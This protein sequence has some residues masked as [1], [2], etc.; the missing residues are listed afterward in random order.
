MLWC[1]SQSLSW[2]RPHSSHSTHP[3]HCYPVSLPLKLFLCLVLLQTSQHAPCLLT[4]CC[5]LTNPGD[6]LI[7]HL[8]ATLNQSSHSNGAIDQ[9]KV[10]DWWLS[11]S[12]VCSWAR[13]DSF[14]ENEQFAPV[15]E[16]MWAAS[17]WLTGIR[18]N[19]SSSFLTHVMTHLFN[20]QDAGFDIRFA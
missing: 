8:L 12:N 5:L 6:D 4:P 2:S 9:L 19:C 1:Q 7:K 16:E 14:R 10:F 20:K 3:A 13:L 18:W 11:W 15:R 17:W